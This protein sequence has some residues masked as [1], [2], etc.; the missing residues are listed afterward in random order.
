MKGLNITVVGAGSSR[1][2]ALVGSIIDYKDSFL[3]KKLIFFDIDNNRMSKMENYIRI[4]LQKELPELEVIF[5]TDKKIAY[6]NCDA[7]LVQMRAG[8]IEMRSLDEKIP[9][10]Y[11]VVGQETCGP[12]GFAYGMRS[13]KAMI[14][15]V[16]DIRNI[17]TNAWILNYTNP[18]A[19]VALA[20]D[21]VFPNDKRILNLCDQPYSMMRSYAKI[22]NLKQSE[23]SCKY[24]GLNHFGW[25]TDIY[26]K[27]G[28]SYLNSLKD[29]LKNNDFK[30][31]NAEQ[32][33]TSWLETYKRV[34]KYLSFFPE[35]LPNTYLQ[36]YFF[37]NE[38]VGESN[39]EYTRADEARD[40]REKEVFE[41]CENA[42]YEN[43]TILKGSVFGNLMVEV[44]RSILYDLKD[45][46]VIMTRNNNLI[47]N[48]SNDAIVELVGKLGKDG[49][50]VEKYGEIKPFYKGL[51]ENQ[52]AYEK[53]TVE[54]CLEEDYDKAI[55]A[56]TLNRTIID[57]QIA[58]K[59]LDDLIDVNKGYWTLKKHN[60]EIK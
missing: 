51:M 36:Y 37:P 6:E 1:T 44:A 55:E 31:Y 41:M 38:I 19:I 11:G 7:V 54:A 14:E 50:I 12:G 28:K 18:A 5:T 23:L 20:L 26:D 57:P 47:T 22:L 4:V 27:N 30:P 39:P 59:V 29:Y 45:E 16:N 43:S 15:M 46:F 42:T 3:L 25:F 48:F 8:N 2:P 35:Y 9:L 60:K 33:S 24:F 40:S 10:K 21:K 53:L 49:V 32:R 34:N 56:L 52:H 58:K 17:N 13:I